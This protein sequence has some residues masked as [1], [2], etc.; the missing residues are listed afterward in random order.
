[1][2]KVMMLD[3]DVKDIGLYTRSVTE[4]EEPE[5]N[6]INRTSGAGTF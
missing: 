3:H 1:M 5:A 6:M 2:D 4:G